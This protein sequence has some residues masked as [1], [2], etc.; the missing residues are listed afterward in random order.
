MAL[1]A[2]TGNHGRL[3]AGVFA[4][5]GHAFPRDTNR[6]QRPDLA[7]DGT[8]TI[9][10]VDVS[11]LL[12]DDTLDPPIRAVFIYNHNPV[13]THPDQNRMR[14]ALARGDVFVAGPTW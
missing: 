1:Q 4:K 7:P 12:L 6:L 5:P 10:I 2:L 14:R 13:A 3:G 9:N 11:R 8:R